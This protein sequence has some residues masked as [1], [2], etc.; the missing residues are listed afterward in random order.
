MRIMGWDGSAELEAAF[1]RY[2]A[3]QAA[4]RYHRKP[5]IKE[6][7]AALEARV[8]LFRCLVDSGWKPPE[9]VLRQISLDAALVHQHHSV[10]DS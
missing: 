5:S 7:D 9:P 2:R 1:A 6:V 3:A 10:L 8:E 4:L